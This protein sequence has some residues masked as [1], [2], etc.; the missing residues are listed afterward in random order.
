MKAIILLI[1]A[2]FILGISSICSLFAEVPNETDSAKNVCATSMDTGD[3]DLYKEGVGHI[4]RS[5]DKREAFV[6][7]YE[8]GISFDGENA[9]QYIDNKKTSLAAFPFDEYDSYAAEILKISH[10][11]ISEKLYTAYG[12]ARSA[13]KEDYYYFKISKEGLALFQNDTYEYGR[14]TCFY[15]DKQ[16]Q[17]FD[18]GLYHTEGERPDLQCTFGKIDYTTVI[19]PAATPSTSP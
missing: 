9:Y 1:T 15:R 4:F 3:Y 16:F 14:I 2:L 18:I 10:T 8:N 12:D 17:Y 7:T 13:Y 19:S 5:G 6:G 11:I